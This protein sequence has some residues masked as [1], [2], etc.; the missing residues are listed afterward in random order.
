M[1]ICL[2]F[3][4]MDNLLLQDLAKTFVKVLGNPKASKQVFNISGSKYVTFDGLA[5]A[6]AKVS[7]VLKKIK[8][9]RIFFIVSFMSDD[10]Y[11][12]FSQAAGFPEPELI[13]YNPKEFEFGKKKAFP[14]RDQVHAYSHQ[15]ALIPLKILTTLC[16]YKHVLHIFF[17]NA[18]VLSKKPTP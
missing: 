6:C 14:F 2:N 4:D 15:S 18:A 3:H 17:T 16:S 1:D 5:K 9:F 12:I 13:H 8:I 11:I 10:L 7:L